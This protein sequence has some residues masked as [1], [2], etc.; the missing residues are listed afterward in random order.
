MQLKKI[1]VSSDTIYEVPKEFSRR[2]SIVSQNDLS[3]YSLLLEAISVCHGV[4]PIKVQTEQGEVIDFQ[5][6][7]P[8]EV[9]LIQSLSSSF[10]RNLT[11]NKNNQIQVKSSFKYGLNKRYKTLYTFQFCS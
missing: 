8:D 3:T 11:E 7:S 4:K 2:A 1:A 9:A 5:G 10:D 6:S